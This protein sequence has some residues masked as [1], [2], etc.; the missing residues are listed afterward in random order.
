M[1]ILDGMKYELMLS[2]HVV[3]YILSDLQSF[4]YMAG[5]CACRV[6][7]KWSWFSYYD[8]IHYLISGSLET[9]L[10]FDTSFKEEVKSHL[11]AK[12]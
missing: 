4:V 1:H 8:R 11:V 7:C 10:L 12:S 6:I 5:F 9:G 3:V 2:V